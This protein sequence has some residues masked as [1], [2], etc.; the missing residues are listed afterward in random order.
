MITSHLKYWRTVPGLATHPVWAAAFTWIE[1]NA[2]DAPD[3]WMDLDDGGLRIGVM[4]YATKSRDTACYE[5]HQ[6]TIDIQYTI[7]GSEKIEVIP[8][9]RLTPKGDYDAEND[10]QLYETPEAG[11]VEVV[12]APG[13]FCILF[14]ED[15]HMPQLR[16]PEHTEVR[17]LVVKVPLAEVR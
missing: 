12:N 2:T 3:G 5:S 11:E 17:K 4:A 13:R 10:G 14:P 8:T 16:A 9:E 1:A 15:A 6:Q 7:S